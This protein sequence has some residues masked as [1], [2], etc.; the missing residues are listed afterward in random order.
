MIHTQLLV[1]GAGPYGLSIAARA[2]DAGIDALVMGEP[3]EFWR[4]NMPERMLLRSGLD[5]H[6]DASGVL[7]LRAYLAERGLDPAHVTP[8]PVGLFIEYAAW[9]RT[10]AGL[11]I[12]CEFVQDITPAGERFDVRLKDGE[13]IIADAVVATTGVARFGSLPDWVDRSLPRDRYSH[14]CELVRFDWLR[15]ARCLIVGGRQSAFEWAALLNEAGVA[16]VHITYRHDTPAFVESD[17]AFVDEYIDRTINVAG[18]YRHLPAAER[19]AVS[20]RFWAEGR[21]KLEPWLTPRLSAPTIQRWP[22]TE[23]TACCVLPSGEI[24]VNLSNGER[25]IV[26][27]VLLGTGYAADASKVSYLRGVFENVEIA[28]GSPVLDEYFQSSVPGLF[29]AGFLAIRDFGPFFGFVRGCPAAATL[30]VR[31]LTRRASVHA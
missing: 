1:V 10:A 5:W 28:D 25:I 31:A 18:W 4:M 26:D 30:I 9:F 3:M 23:V 22:Q 21:L 2:K 14:T 27:H 15:G 17:W 19:E 8:L 29:F 11:S 24:Q 13:R 20:Q 7:S 6:L 16:A 12:W